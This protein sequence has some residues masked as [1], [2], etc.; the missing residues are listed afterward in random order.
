MPPLSHWHFFAALSVDSSAAGTWRASDPL[1][2]QSTEPVMFSALR[3][4]HRGVSVHSGLQYPKSR[5]TCPG[6]FVV[7]RS[8]SSCGRWFLTRW[9]YP[10]SALGRWCLRLLDERWHPKLPTAKWLFILGSALLHKIEVLK[11]IPNYTKHYCLQS[12]PSNP[13][14]PWTNHP[15]VCNGRSLSGIGLTRERW[16]CT[17]RW[18]SR[19]D[20]NTCQTSIKTDILLYCCSRHLGFTRQT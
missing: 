19:L 10:Q 9:R 15:L 4:V 12:I 1:A 3:R 14:K 2:Q 13:Q 17:V 18:L 20:M 5:F 7:A 8:L 16:C 6:V 11:K